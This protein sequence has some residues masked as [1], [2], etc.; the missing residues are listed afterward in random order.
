MRSRRIACLLLG[1][2]MG[3]GLWMLWVAA[4]NTASAS[5]LLLAPNAYAAEYLKTLGRAQLSPLTHY[6]AAEQN[7]S[8]FETWGV[9]QIVF[10]SLFFALLLFGTR[11]GKFPLAVALLMLLIVIGE[12][13]AIAPGM[14]LVALHTDFNPSPSGRAQL[15]NAAIDFGY[16][17]AEWA[18]FSLGAVI[19]VVLIWQER[20]RSLDARKQVD[21][22]NKTDYRHIDR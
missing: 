1:L 22:V 14:E 3:A 21:L 12:R 19:A 17:I 20:R 16:K 13:A 2:W 4:D 5:R 9:V 11:L 6:L 7:R 15:A 10:G 18:K 8:L